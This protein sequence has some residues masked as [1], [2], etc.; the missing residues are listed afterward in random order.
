MDCEDVLSNEKFNAAYLII[1]EIIT[2]CG[3]KYLLENM[4]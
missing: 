4:Q 3:D 1:A 2:K